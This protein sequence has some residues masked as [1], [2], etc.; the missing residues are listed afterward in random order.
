MVE[1]D[2]N[3][4]GALDECRNEDDVFDVDMSDEVPVGDGLVGFYVSI[5]AKRNLSRG[6]SWQLHI[7]YPNWH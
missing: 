2:E 4:K 3:E 7:L 5:T 6:E 1:A